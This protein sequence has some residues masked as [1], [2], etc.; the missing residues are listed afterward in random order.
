MQGSEPPVG[1]G[2]AA[3]RD[4]LRS[5]V[6]RILDAA[7]QAVD[8]G[9]AVRRFVESAGDRLRI[10]ERL[11]DLGRVDRVMVLGAGK[12]SASMARAV[13]EMLGDR[14]GGGLVV[15]KYGYV[16]A[17]RRIELREAGHPVP[18]EAGERAAE[19]IL[20]MATGAGENDLLIC[21]IS[22]GGSAL[23]PLPV[24]S[25]ALE[26][27]QAA[28]SLLLRSGATIDEMNA[29]RKHISRIKGGRL[30]EAAAPA[31]I[32]TLM[33]S[34]VIGD[35]LDVIASGP[36]VPDESTFGESIEI[37]SKYHLADELP[38]P[39]L[40]HLHRGARGEIRETPKP[41]DPLFEGTYNVVVGN[42]AG[43]LMAAKEEASRLGYAVHI[44]SSSVQGEARDVA[45]EHVALARRVRRTGAP[46]RPPCCLI[47]GGETTVTVRGR[48]KGGRNQEFAL[49][50]A[51]AMQGMEEV[52]VLSAGTD[53]TDGPTDAAGALAD[54]GTV[55]RARALGID[56][57]A[58]LEENDSYT[59][60][61]ALD[62]LVMTGPT[63]TNVM[64]IQLILVAS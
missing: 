23:L 54:G 5:D 32:V 60:F 6:R 18:D 8:A 13:E 4:R 7:L 37:V 12:A 14:I 21:L 53:G 51:I 34:D 31:Q 41:G 49:A 16:A 19:Q 48:G 28:T 46:V 52:V 30:A 36:T 17:L 10:S 15:T 56:A 57:E 27:K 43:A 55:E 26:E 40:A 2:Q 59:F 61:S 45:K 39:V 47:S 24:R 64:D 9:R 25:I 63:T 29:L 22:G 42:N 44:G 20:A 50:A 62:G 58:A 38:S 33:L 3:P 35:R 11:F 1:P